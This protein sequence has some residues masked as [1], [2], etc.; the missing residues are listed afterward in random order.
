MDQ[1]P[2]GPLQSAKTGVTGEDGRDRRGR[3]WWAE[4]GVGQE[5]GWFRIDMV[6]YFLSSKGETKREE[7]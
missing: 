4:K 1:P 3:E 6:T 5:I 2:P 7:G